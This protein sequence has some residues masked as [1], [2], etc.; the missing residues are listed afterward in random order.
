MEQMKVA[1]EARD[2]SVLTE[3]MR[4]GYVTMSPLISRFENLVLD[5]VNGDGLVPDEAEVKFTHSGSPIL[6]FCVMNTEVEVA[7]KS[8]NGDRRPIKSYKDSKID[9]AVAMLMALG[10]GVYEENMIT[11]F[12]DLAW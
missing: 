7:E 5:A 6:T 11:S 9:C 1:M 10:D 12:E 2:V 8:I 4:Q 3:P